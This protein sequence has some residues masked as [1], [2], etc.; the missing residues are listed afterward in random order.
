[1][2]LQKETKLPISSW[3][4]IWRYF[5]QLGTFSFFVRES[6]NLKYYENL[7]NCNHGTETLKL[8]SRRMISM[9]FSFQWLLHETFPSNTDVNQDTFVT[10][11]LHLLIE[12]FV[13]HRKSP[14]NPAEIKDSCLLKDLQD[15][16]SFFQGK[17]WNFQV[18]PRCSP[19]TDLGEVDN[20]NSFSS[21]FESGG[22]FD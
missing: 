7:L 2:I 14:R 13:G 3:Q 9:S 4:E 11:I 6:N 10:E 1:M 17:P 5:S 8:V 20:A 21:A 16:E 12:T 22:N 19:A 18:V 15:W